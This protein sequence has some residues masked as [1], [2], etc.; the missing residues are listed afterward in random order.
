MLLLL[1][2]AVDFYVEPLGLAYLA[3]IDDAVD[4]TIIANAAAGGV[5][6][7]ET[8]LPFNASAPRRLAIGSLQV[9]TESQPRWPRRFCQF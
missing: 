4:A 8:P 9:K 5:A 6:G 1:L 3:R 2:L 7:R